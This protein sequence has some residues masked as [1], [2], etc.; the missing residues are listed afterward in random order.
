ML[1]LDNFLFAIDNKDKIYPIFIIDREHAAL[2]NN[3]KHTTVEESNIPDLNY[4][5]YAVLKYK[6]NFAIPF[7]DK[8]EPSPIYKVLNYYDISSD[9]LVIINAKHKQFNYKISSYYKKHEKVKDSIYYS[10]GL[11]IQQKLQCKHF[12]TKMIITGNDKSIINRALLAF[13]DFSASIKLLN[14]LSYI[15]S[16]P[17]YSILYKDNILSHI[18]LLSLMLPDSIDNVRLNIDGVRP[19][20]NS[21]M[22]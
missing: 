3:I 20:S 1:R 18:E 4:R 7:T 15:I 17:R 8:A 6:R 11:S 21:D 16:K 14:D 5:Y 10:H 22:I 2:L 13:R 19:Y 9:C 12:I